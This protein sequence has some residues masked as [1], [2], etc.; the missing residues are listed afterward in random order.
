MEVF[1]LLLF[2]CFGSVCFVGFLGRLEGFHVCLV[3]FCGL[4]GWLV[5]GWFVLNKKKQYLKLSTVFQVSVH[6]LTGSYN[7]FP[8]TL[9]TK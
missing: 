6:Y 8:I 1:S 9:E 5:V 7:I 3:L 4:F 2:F